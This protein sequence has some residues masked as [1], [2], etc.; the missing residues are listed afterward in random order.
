MGPHIISQDRAHDFGVVADHTPISNGC[1]AHERVVGDDC[2]FADHT[3]ADD[4]GMG[5]HFHILTQYDVTV[6]DRTGMN[7]GG[8]VD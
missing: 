6:H 2:P 3:R 1:V 7:H 5:H 8:F 4:G